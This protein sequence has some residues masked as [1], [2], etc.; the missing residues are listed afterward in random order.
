MH[1][2][3]LNTTDKLLRAAALDSLIAELGE[4]FA[5]FVTCD[6]KSEM[7]EERID[8]IKRRSGLALAA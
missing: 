7:I 5:A 1:T 3:D 4:D 6:E 8:L 2:S